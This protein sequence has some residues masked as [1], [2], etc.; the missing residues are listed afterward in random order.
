[1][2]P[3][4][5]LPLSMALIEQARAFLSG[6][7][8]RTPLEESPALSQIA[9]SPVRLKLECLQKTGSFKIR[10][11]LFRLSLLTEEEK[12]AGI[13]TCS[14]GNHGKAVAYAARSQG[15]RP[16]IYLPASVDAS[17]LRAIEALGA[18]VVVSRF[19]G[20]DETEEWALAEAAREGRV[21]ISAFDD[22]AIMAGNGGTLALEILEEMPEARNFVLP[23]GGGGMSGGLAFVVAERVPGAVVVG[24]QHEESPALA[25]SL[26]RGEAVT[27]LPAVETSAGGIEGGIGR[28]TFAV[29]RPR[30]GRVALVSEEEIFEGV[31]W[32]LE[33]H[34]YLVEPS[35]AAAVAACLTGKAGRFD[36]PVAVVI[37][38]RN[39]SLPTLRRIFDSQPETAR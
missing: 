34:Q 19:P 15:L 3:N 16:R 33:H 24:C 14:A 18:D 29:L 36:A 17:K 11:A 20:Y 9:G 32:M 28:R 7:I 1:M 4:A 21:W 8:R 30:I 31:R 27:R 23:V 38:G 35:S 37:S 13:A 26:E 22:D 10:G 6:R 5:I 25:L 39:V 2:T 12:Q